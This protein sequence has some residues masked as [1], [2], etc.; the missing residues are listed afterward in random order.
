MK[1]LPSHI[2]VILIAVPIVVGAVAFFWFRSTSAALRDAA[3]STDAEVNVS[4]PTADD[5]NAAA[6]AAAPV[7]VPVAEFVAPISDALS[8][9]TKKPFG[10]QIIPGHSPVE[11][12]RFTGFHVGVDFE[13]TPEEQDADI[14]ITAACDGK[15]LLKKQATGYGGVAA[16]SCQLDG[17]EVTVVYGHLSLATIVPEV[18]D[19][20][21]QGDRIGLLGKGNSPE[22]DGVRKHLHL[23]IHRGPDLNILG[24]VQ[25]ESRVGEWLDA[26]A[27]IKE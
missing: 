8:R 12:D 21:V 1:K 7:E 20:L 6:T 26:L 18:G 13:T 25:D 22:T 23:G 2:V 15:L 3:Q 14:P 11:H 16:Q 5:V 4:L 27:S 10:L 17:Q 24:Y 9:V 19:A